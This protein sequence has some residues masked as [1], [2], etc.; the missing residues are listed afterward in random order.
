MPKRVLD[1]IDFEAERE[2]AAVARSRQQVCKPYGW[3]KAIIKQR[4][5][6]KDGEARV[7]CRTVKQRFERYA[8]A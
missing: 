1:P 7:E 5:M 2:G 8:H 6:P 4:R 3:N